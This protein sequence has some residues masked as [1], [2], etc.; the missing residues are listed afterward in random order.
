MYKILYEDIRDYKIKEA[1]ISPQIPPNNIKIIKEMFGL[2][3]KKIA[4]KLDIDPRFL[5]AVS[6]NRA[7]FSG[8]ITLKFLNEF[9]LSFSSVYDV[10]STIE[11]NCENYKLVTIIL[12]INKNSS[13]NKYQ[14]INSVVEDNNDNNSLS[15]VRYFDLEF[16]NN[17][18]DLN[19]NDGRYIDE[20]RKEILLDS[21]DN[22]NKSN[23][24]L[25]SK[26]DYMLIT[27]LKKTYTP[28]VITINTGDSLDIETDN[29]L[30]S[31]PFKKLVNVSIP[32]SDYEIHLG[33]IKLDRNYNI[34]RDNKIHHT[35][36]LNKN[37]YTFMEDKKTIV[38]K[39]FSSEDTI[40]KLA[41]YRYIKGYD[42]FY[43]ANALNLTVESYRLLES[44]H[45]RLTTH[46]MWK[47]E[48]CFG[49][50]LENIIDV[51][52][53]YEKLFK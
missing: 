26:N 1:F 9:N 35:N 53:Y 17:L 27:F 51:A 25:S 30:F 45:N 52:S 19:L 2:T 4:K 5:C 12:S 10:Q 20:Y 29:I 33:K 39:A 32:S 42:M 23:I 50:Q 15:F 40:N 8:A 44:G 13:F 3:D 18:F 16:N 31:A 14:I 43:M 7:I 46:Q 24:E 34:F 48:N 36:T 49:I 21:I 47:L 11:T 6:N 38:F 37:E 22:L 41:L 28:K